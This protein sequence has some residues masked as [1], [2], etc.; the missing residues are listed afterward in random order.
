MASRKEGKK[1]EEELELDLN[2]LRDEEK[3]KREKLREKEMKNKP[4]VEKKM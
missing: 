2:K 1:D 3:V 4:E